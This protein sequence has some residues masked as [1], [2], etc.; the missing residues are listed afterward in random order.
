MGSSAQLAFAAHSTQVPERQMGRAGSVQS[1]LTVHWPKTMEKY[2]VFCFLG[3]IAFCS[4][5]CTSAHQLQSKEGGD[6][7][8]LHAKGFFF[9]RLLLRKWILSHC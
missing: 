7:K 8:G 9:L 1:R 5:Y 2:K 4:I 6:E 3:E